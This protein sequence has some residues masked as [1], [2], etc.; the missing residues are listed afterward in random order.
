MKFKP[1]RLQ[2]ESY[3]IKSIDWAIRVLGC[4]SF[5][6]GH[7]TLG[8]LS[9]LTGFPKPTLFRILLTLG[10]NR[11]VSYNPTSGQY[12]LGMRLFELG[13]VAVS[14]TSLRQ[15]AS[16]FLDALEMETGYPALLGILDEGELVY[17]DGRAG[18]R[19]PCLEH[20]MGSGKRRTW[21]SSGRH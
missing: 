21:V 1:R 3:S 15:E 4:F 14:S 12:S 6:R 18:N 11:F 8:Q 5:E 7:L 10:K 19:G 16:R 2:S 17:I 13:E 20:V 9:G